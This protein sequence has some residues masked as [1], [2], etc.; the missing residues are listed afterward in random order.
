MPTMVMCQAPLRVMPPRA[1]ARPGHDGVHRRFTSSAGPT[2]GSGCRCASGQDERANRH[3]G[4]VILGLQAGKGISPGATPSRTVPPIV[5]ALA[6]GAWMPS[7]GQRCPP[8][9]G[10]PSRGRALAWPW[11]LFRNRS[12]GTI[13]ARWRPGHGVAIPPPPRRVQSPPR[14]CIGVGGLD[15]CT[16][17]RMPV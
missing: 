14:W 8:A 9:T 11:P 4:L 16:S 6:A 13:I 5:R 3:Q 7:H 2:S 1:P 10:P 12:S 15:G 17:A